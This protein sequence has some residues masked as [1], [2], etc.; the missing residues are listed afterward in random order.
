MRDLVLFAACCALAA[1]FWLSSSSRVEKRQEA[2]QTE[3]QQLG[4]PQGMEDSPER[5]LLQGDYAA[6]LK[7]EPSDSTYEKLAALYL[8]QHEVEGKGVITS[9]VL[10]D[11]MGR[12][13]G[14]RLQFFD[15]LG[16]ATTPRLSRL[17]VKG[18]PS[19]ATPFRS[20][21]A[22]E[23]VAD[24]AWLV[25]RDK[26]RWAVFRPWDGELEGWILDQELS[27]DGDAVLLK[28]QRTWT[29]SDGK[30]EREPAE[31]Q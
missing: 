21:G 27:V 18:E 31:G 16:K 28:G 14:D 29:W 8:V 19:Q 15:P 30:L 23:M 22:P 6:G 17:K 4:A 25:Y 5:S 9:A 12:V 11:S 20:A 3:L 10:P 7:A 1:A 13:L 26:A 2:R 24:G